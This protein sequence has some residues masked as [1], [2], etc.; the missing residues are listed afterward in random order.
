LGEVV[1]LLREL[2]RQ[3]AD[4]LA[5]DFTRVCQSCGFL[6]EPELRQRNLYD[7]VVHPLTVGGEKVAVFLVDAFRYEMAV[8]LYEELRASGTPSTSV[9]LSPRLA[10]LPTITAVGMNVL[11]PVVKDERLNVVG[12]F[13]GFRSGEFTVRDPEGRSRAIGMRAE[14]QAALHIELAELC[15]KTQKVLAR[16]KNHRVVVV[17]SCELDSAGEA[18]VGVEAF[19]AILR[20]L[21]AAWYHLQGAGIKQAVFTADHGFLIQDATA[22]TVPF[23]KKTDPQ[24]RYVLDQYE[25]HEQ[26]VVP[27]PLASL[28]YDGIDGY[29]LLR[30]DTADFE[31][32]DKGR[33]F[34]HGGN[35]PQER[36][37]PVLTVARKESEGAFVSQYKIETRAGEGGATFHRLQVRLTFPPNCEN[38]LPFVGP[39]SVDLGLRVPGRTDIRVSLREVAGD[40]KL[41]QGRI[42]A[43]V[44]DWIDVSFSLEGKV[45]ERV[46]VEVFHPDNIHKVTPALAE[47]MFGVVGLTTAAAPA[48]ATSWAANIAD[49][50]VR[51][52]FV[53]LGEHGVITEEEITRKL[54]SARAARQFSLGFDG[55]L[56]FL[57]WKARIE[58][59]ASG[60][61]YVREED[62]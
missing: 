11:A 59:N 1:I 4:S 37:I 52:V 43:N 12:K 23:G 14:G 16:V 58:S 54:G 53:H 31:T 60:K 57:P 24:R 21:R 19:E 32:K 56:K 25:R 26:G 7:Q 45:D 42:Q 46:P 55:Y 10:E 47:G 34:V 49:E 40:G 36:F 41:A 33:T 6:P 44:K 3:W 51:A 35:S 17:H 18:N 39:R 9:K 15:D 22:K 13:E 48:P 50:R 27:V 29:L 28:G 2:Y 30:E 38:T 62:K 8:G 20:R 5:R 61:R